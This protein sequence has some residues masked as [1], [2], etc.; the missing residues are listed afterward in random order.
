MP[1]LGN[2]HSK[3]IH[4]TS[5]NNN[6]WIRRIPLTFSPSAVSIDIMDKA[7]LCF[8]TSLTLDAGITT[9]N[10][11]TTCFIFWFLQKENIWVMSSQR[12][13][14]TDNQSK[15]QACSPPILMSPVWMSAS[16][17]R[18]CYLCF[19]EQHRRV[20]AHMMLGHK[21]FAVIEDLLLQGTGERC[22][23]D[24]HTQTQQG[25]FEVVR[26]FS[27][28]KK[29]S[30]TLTCFSSCRPPCWKKTSIDQQHQDQKCCFFPAGHSNKM[31]N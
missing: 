17:V 6:W 25:S 7:E 12:G 31:Q 23:T 2:I 24:R 9:Y 22:N 30:L 26:W 11:T 19:F 4:I 5:K 10:V 28:N 20:E 14:H 18:A 27:K 8:F 13:R 29:N 1:F 15:E 21:E 16:T 3:A